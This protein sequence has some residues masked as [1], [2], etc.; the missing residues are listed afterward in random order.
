MAFTVL[1][2][3]FTGQNLNQSFPSR[4]PGTAKGWDTSS[5]NREVIIDPALAAG[6]EILPSLP[7]KLLTSATGMKEVCTLCTAGTDTVYGYVIYKA[8]NIVNTGQYNRIA[9]VARDGQEM[10]FAFKK[11]ITPGATVYMDP[12]DGLCTPDANDGASAP[13]AYL[14]VGLA[15]EAVVG[16]SASAPV[17]GRVEVQ[18]PRV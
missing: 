11:A 15:L 10:D 17:M 4:I 2:S 1:K 8:K 5:R 9:T 14:K 12:S 7:L 6:T 13:V 16:P 18:T 3:L